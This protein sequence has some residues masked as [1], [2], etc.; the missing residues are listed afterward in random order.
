MLA[1]VIGM[2]ARARLSF[3]LFLYQR[4][5]ARSG[6]DGDFATRE[7]GHS[8]QRLTLGGDDVYFRVPAQTTSRSPD[9]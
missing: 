3:A 5:A 8:E 9:I 6:V 1:D 4:F 2:P 7:K